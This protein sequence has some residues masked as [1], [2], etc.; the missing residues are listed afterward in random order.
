MTVHTWGNGTDNKIVIH[1]SVE[2][3][4]FTFIAFLKNIAL[5]KK[6]RIF[7]EKR[8]RRSIC[9]PIVIGGNKLTNQIRVIIAYII[10][11]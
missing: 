6:Y 4:W 3:F 7:T 8:Y 10:G 5:L 1:D 9:F 2:L 11:H